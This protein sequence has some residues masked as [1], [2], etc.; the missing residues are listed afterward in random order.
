LPSLMFMMFLMCIFRLS[1]LTLGICRLNISLIEPGVRMLIRFASS[2]V[3]CSAIR[4]SVYPVTLP[5]AV[6]FHR[7][8]PVLEAQIVDVCDIAR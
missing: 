5:N 6:V 1:Q 4:K 8:T 2:S 7:V 3:I